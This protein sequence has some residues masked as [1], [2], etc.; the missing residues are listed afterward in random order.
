MK[1]LITPQQ[2]YLQ[3]NAVGLRTLVIVA[4][5][6]CVGAHDTAQAAPLTG[7]GPH[8]LGP[9]SATAG[10]STSFPTT[11]VIDANNRTATWPNMNGEQVP[12]GY[13]GTYTAT[14]PNPSDLNIATGLT[15]YNFTGLAFGVLPAG[16]HFNL[17][18]LDAGNGNEMYTFMAFGP[19]HILL[20]T[21]W[22]DDLALTIFDGNGANIPSATDTPGWNWNGSTYT[23]DGSMVPGN[24][25]VAARLQSLANIESLEF[26]RN[27]SSNTFNIG[28]PLVP[29]PTTWVLLSLAIPVLLGFRRRTLLRS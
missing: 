10:V 21:P 23:F 1:K 12:A 13:V 16:A 4:L 14:G 7:S 25:S 8:I 17:A 27:S 29:E 2:T 20:T 19:G 26:S 11:T 3:Y 5:A 18:D 22:F 6:L 9:R 24:P 28:A 15:T